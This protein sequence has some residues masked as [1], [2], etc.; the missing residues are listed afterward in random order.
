M[1]YVRTVKAKSAVTAVQT[2]H[3]SRRKSR[4]IEPI[5]STHDEAGL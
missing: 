3:S 4:E 2:V 1:P 5:G